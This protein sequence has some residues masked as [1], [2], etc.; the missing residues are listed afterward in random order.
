MKSD[1]VFLS[2]DG[3]LT[4]SSA[5]HLRNLAAVKANEIL[6]QLEN[7]SFVNEYIGLIDSKE[8]N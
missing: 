6:S 3:K 2:V 7:L 5:S 4:M 1:Y 8:F